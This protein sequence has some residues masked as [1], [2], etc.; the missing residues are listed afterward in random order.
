[1]NKAFLIM[2]IAASSI[3]AVMSTS[4]GSM[5]LWNGFEGLTQ[6]DVSDTGVGGDPDGDGIPDGYAIN[7]DDSTVADPL[8]TGD[9]TI[10]DP[11]QRTLDRTVFVQPVN[12]YTGMLLVNDTLLSDEYMPSNQGLISPPAPGAEGSDNYV[13]LFDGGYGNGMITVVEN[14]ITEPGEHTISL[15][16][17]VFDEDADG[18]GVNAEIADI[19]GDVNEDITDLYVQFGPFYFDL[20]SA[21]REDLEETFNVAT[22]VAAE[23]ETAEEMDYSPPAEG[24]RNPADEPFDGEWVKISTTHN[25]LDPGH[26]AIVIH[27]AFPFPGLDGALDITAMALDHFVIEGPSF[28]DTPVEDWA[29][30]P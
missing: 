18:D 24:D 21:L 16:A 29:I 10:Q 11:S 20:D 1:M 30:H 13:M 4:A 5:L 7:A 25:F 3:W 15:Y 22:S 9:M 12:A 26:V 17:K 8:L 14:L 19:D 28:P 23:P 6:A 27:A 2:L